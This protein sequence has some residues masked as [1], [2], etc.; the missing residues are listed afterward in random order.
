MYVNLKM[1]LENESKVDQSER[2]NTQIHNCK[3]KFDILLSVFDRRSKQKVSGAQMIRP[4]G[5][6]P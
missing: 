2:R 5:V 4:I 1:E 6:E 3:E